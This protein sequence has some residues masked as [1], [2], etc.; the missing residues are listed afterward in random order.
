MWGQK[1]IGVPYATLKELSCLE[2]WRSAQPRLRLRC[3]IVGGFP[4]FGDWMEGRK[5]GADVCLMASS[6]SSHK[7]EARREISHQYPLTSLVLMHFSF[8]Q[9][10]CRSP[11]V[12]LSILH[13]ECATP[14]A[15]RAA[16]KASSS[17]SFRHSRFHFSITTTR[18]RASER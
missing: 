15:F 7:N 1:K 3:F 12:P 8:H 17:S 9:F 10:E 4:S 18:T 13:V 6:S 14:S 16:F 11:K 2:M 5:L